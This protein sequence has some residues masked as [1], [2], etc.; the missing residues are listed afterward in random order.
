MGCGAILYGAVVEKA[1]FKVNLGLIEEMKLDLKRRGA[2]FEDSLGDRSG[3]QERSLILNF[4]S[5]NGS[6]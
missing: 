2:I 3:V 6:C 5:L 4:P 1:L